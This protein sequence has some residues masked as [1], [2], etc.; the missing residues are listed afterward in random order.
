MEVPI[1]Q[2]LIAVKNAAAVTKSTA[3]ERILNSLQKETVVWVEA[4]LTKLE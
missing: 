2:Y 1:F 4:R 3:K